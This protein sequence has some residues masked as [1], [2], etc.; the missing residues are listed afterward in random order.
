MKRQQRTGWMAVIAGA[1]LALSA[2]GCGSG[3]GGG[4][5]GGIDGPP[6]GKA[7]ALTNY[8][9]C[10]ELLADAKAVLLD[11]LDEYIAPY[12]N[13]LDCR[14]RVVATAQ[15]GDAASAVDATGTNVQEAGVDEGDLIKLDGDYA[16][17]IVG[18]EVQI[19]RV[20]PFTEFERVA[21][22]STRAHELYVSQGKLVVIAE[23][24]RDE[25]SFCKTC[26]D[27]P[28]DP[29]AT[30]AIYDV[31]DPAHPSLL[32]TVTS[33]GIFGRIIGSRLV[34]SRLYV[35]TDSA[36]IVEPDLNFEIT[37]SFSCDGDVPVNESGF[38]DAVEA[39]RE[40]N[41][42]IIE[43]AT[44]EELIPMVGQGRIAC[45]DIQR[46]G[47][48]MGMRFV[49][50]LEDDIVDPQSSPAEHRIIGSGG[51]LYASPNALYVASVARPFS[52][53]T[54]MGTEPSDATIIHR[55][56]LSEQG[57]A[58]TA[59]AKVDGELVGNT[60]AG[61]RY[62]ARFS[63]SQFAMSEYE[64]YLRVATT[65]HTPSQDDP[66]LNAATDNK[67]FVLDAGNGQMDLVGEVGGMG[68]GETIHAVRFVGDRGYI[69]TFK[70]TDP[71]YVVDLS[72]PSAPQVAGELEVP[73]FSTYLHPLDEGHL[74]GLGF[75][76]DDMGP[77]A[78]TQG[79]K[80]ALFDVT[81]SSM[82]AIVGSR[83]VGSRGSYSAAIEEH[84]A[85]TLDTLRGI[86]A[87]PVELYE[88]GAGGGDFGTPTFAGVMLFKVDLSGSFATVGRFAVD[89]VSQQ[90]EP[91][92]WMG[93]PANILR[94]AIL[95]D[96]KEDGVITLS[97]SGVQLNRI[98]AT[99]SQVAPVAL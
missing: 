33:E 57:A 92:W 6:S 24:A 26:Y 62:S 10:G 18:G 15:E 66:F 74:V 38:L 36:G 42:A 84:H 20:W 80:L 70:K 96:G 61:S 67:V 13:G 56:S 69:V 51:A 45:E 25:G 9:N 86:L 72:A 83:E 58:Y 95:G 52:W 94:T 50:L 4:G 97:T 44:L 53:W 3:T 1:A 23:S 85:F 91:S 75:N 87:L 93:E 90:S 65:V 7:L 71:L 76:A 28:I 77:F 21:R 40:R 37:A 19:Y 63:M 99:M 11:R 12:R 59:S 88:G 54:M 30:I 89:G 68:A 60:F 29:V 82:P 5:G 2:A 81:D 14:N 46:S 32:K 98:D 79:L 78:W 34:G 27:L 16:Y 64:G 73:G 22:I 49:T 48:A 47:V 41:R 55:F 17:A 43:A 35:A 39:M 31:A 8:A